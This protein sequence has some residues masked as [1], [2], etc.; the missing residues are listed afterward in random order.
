MK[1]IFI[2][3]AVLVVLTSF[4]NSEK[5]TNPVTATINTYSISTDKAVYRPGDKVLLTLNILPADDAF[6]RYWHLDE[7]LGEAPLTSASWSWQP[8]STDYSGYLVEVYRKKNGIEKTLASIAVDVSSDW[9]K[10]PR[11]GFLSAFGR[12]ADTGM[13]SVINNLNR[14]HIN[15][16]QFYDWQYAHHLPLAGT[17]ANPAAHWQDIAHR[18]TYRAT[19]QQYIQLAHDHN[20]KAMSYD[21]CYGALNDAAS[22]GVSDQWYMYTDQNHAN[23]AV[24]KMLASMFKSDIWLMD[25]SNSNWQNYLTAKNNDMYVVYDFDGYHVDQM[26]DLGKHYTYSGSAINLE[27]GFGDFLLAMKLAAPSK[28][29]VMNA[30]NQ[31]GQQRSISK[32][33]VDFLYTEVWAPNEGYADL[34]RIIQDN[35]AFSGYTKKTVLTAY[36]NYKLAD[37]PGYFNEPGVLLT[38]AVIFSFG[39]SHLELGD[40]MLCKDY[41]PNNNLH[42]TP[43]LDKTIISYYDFLVANENLLRGGGVFN[44][45]P[46]TCSNAKMNIGAWPPQAGK[47]A[48]QGKKV[49]NRQVLH[50]INF[51]NAVHLNWRDTDGNQTTP[52]AITGAAIELTYGGIASKVWIASPDDNNGVPHQLSFVQKG[53]TLK[54]I[55]PDLKYW[56]MVVIE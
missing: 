3:C 39:G 22:A 18:D 29:L 14:C 32:S 21:L 36:M 55:L 28:K 1:K 9:G 23:K 35:D 34:A 31:F 19:V 4:K 10:F 43:E 37:K 11:Y 20:M 33:P 25:P 56:D 12:M 26:G 7:V 51:A 53:D 27:S 45:V 38:N 41:F 24:L 54:F 17:V 15:G 16:L 30:V 52:A 47:V 50:F 6:V 2:Y 5:Y 13:L 44:T 40:H 42:T 48:V 8:P 49:G 46:M